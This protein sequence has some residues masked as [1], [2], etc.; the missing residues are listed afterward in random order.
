MLIDQFGE[1]YELELLKP[2][3]FA[4]ARL[5]AQYYDYSFQE[6]MQFNSYIKH[7]KVFTVLCVKGEYSEYS[8]KKIEF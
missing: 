4:A 8:K 3:A 5:W 2:C 6:R 1:Y 7:I